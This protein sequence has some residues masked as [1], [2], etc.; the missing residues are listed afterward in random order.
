MRFLKR[1]LRRPRPD[2][3][4]KMRRKAR[5][6]IPPEIGIEQFF[7]TLGERNVR[8]AL[9]RWFDRLPDVKPGS[10]IDLLIHDDDIELLS[11]LL[12]GSKRGIPC[13]LFS[14]SGLPGTAYRGYEGMPYLPPERAAG[15]IDRAVNFK[16]IYR[17]PSPEDHFLSLAYHAIYQK[18]LKS[19][20]PTSEPALRPDPTPRHDYAAILARLAEAVGFDVEMTMEGLDDYLAGRG[21]RPPPPMLAKLAEKNPWL[22]SRLTLHAA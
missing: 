21:W 18:G 3:H 16:N 9:L 19:G 15:L 1:L 11:D 20:L 4:G 2:A 13:D 12:I 7:G 8:Y 14:V 10:D 22:E 5:R 6:Y 17:V